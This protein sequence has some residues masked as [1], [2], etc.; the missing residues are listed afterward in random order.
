MA[1]TEALDDESMSPRGPAVFTAQ[2][3]QRRGTVRG[4]GWLD[5]RGADLLSGSVDTLRR[6]GHRHITVTL[7]RPWMA[8]PAAWELL[9]GEVDRQAAQGVRL[10]LR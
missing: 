9:A 7:V 1:E 2:I 10:I 3:D 4:R 6:R 8:E 5:R